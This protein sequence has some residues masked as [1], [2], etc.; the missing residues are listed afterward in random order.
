MKFTVLT[1]N[2]HSGSDSNNKY[3]LEATIAVLKASGAEV[4]SLQ[5]VDR[6]WGQRSDNDDQVKILSK[7]LKMQ[8][9][10]AANLS[11]NSNGSNKCEFGNLLLSKFKLVESEITKIYIGNNQNLKY[12]G[13]R[14]TEPRSIIQAKLDIDGHNVWI[15]NTHLS[16][17]LPKETEKQS[18]AIEERLKSNNDPL[19]LM[20]DFNS[21][22]DSEVLNRFSKYLSNPTKGK[23]LITHESAKGQIDYIL[24]RGITVLQIDVI[25]S[26][27]SDHL[28]LVAQLELDVE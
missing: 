16:L 28:P 6:N 17:D 23:N 24:T 9:V 25:K 27:A 8:S 13:T 1:Y 10:F 18:L 7:E 19:V 3:D 20:G 12:D 2:I 22:P 26:D 15:L 5:E 4:I 21:L 14:K 11:E